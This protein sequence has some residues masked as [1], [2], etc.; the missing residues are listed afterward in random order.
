MT[1]DTDEAGTGIAG[2]DDVLG[3]GLSRGHAGAEKR[4]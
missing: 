4:Q 2:L 3:G 1:T